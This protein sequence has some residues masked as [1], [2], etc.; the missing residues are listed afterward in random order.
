MFTRYASAILTGTL[1]TMGLLFVMQALISMQPAVETEPRPRLTLGKMKIPEPLPPPQPPE[2]ID[3]ELL[4]KSPVPPTRLAPEGHGSGVGVNI[5]PQTVPDNSYR[6]TLQQ[7]TDGPLVALIRVAPTYP[8]AATTRELEGWVIVQFDV[9]ANGLVGNVEV[10]ESSH[11][12][13]ERN[14]IKAAQR[15]KFKPRVVDG[16]PQVSRNIQ[17]QFTFTLDEEDNSG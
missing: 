17:N 5:P 16:E 4:T 11:T 12:V 14:A 3:P 6:P 9:L 8:P 13:F 7:Y 15:F 1:V 2:Q 10:V